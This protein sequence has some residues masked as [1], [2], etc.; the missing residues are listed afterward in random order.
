MESWHPEVALVIATMASR[1][2]GQ[3]PVLLRGQ[4]SVMLLQA[5]LPVVLLLCEHPIL[6][7]SEE[8]SVVGVVTARALPSKISEYNQSLTMTHYD[9]IP[10][11]IRGV[12]HVRIKHRVL[13]LGVVGRGLRI[14]RTAVVVGEVGE[15]VG[16]LVAGVSLGLGL[17]HV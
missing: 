11:L 14:A 13:H 16:V 17:H 2:R 10:V 8:S 7:I 3:S 6:F 5:A 12:L 9:I 4:L 15:I 1:Q